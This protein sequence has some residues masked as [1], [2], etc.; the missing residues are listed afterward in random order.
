M[1]HIQK[2]VIPVISLV[3]ISTY[4]CAS[5]GEGTTEPGTVA[6]PTFS[7]ASGNYGLA[8]SVQITSAT[9]GAS[10][11]YTTNGTEPSCNESNCSSGSLYSSALNVDSSQT[12]KAI[13]CKAGMNQS[14]VANAEYLVVLIGYQSGDSAASVTG[15]L[16]LPS[17]DAKG[18]SVS[19][20]SSNTTAITNTG[21]ITRPQNGA[22]NA[23]ST[24]TATV[25]LSSGD[26]TILYDLTVLAWRLKT[27]KIYSPGPDEQLET[28]DDVWTTR[29]D[30]NHDASGRVTSYLSRNAGADKTFNTGDDSLSGFSYE[31]D[32]NGRR[33]YFITRSVGS[34]GTWFTDDDPFT[35]VRKYTYNANGKELKNL[36]YN[37]A[38]SDTNWKTSDDVLNNYILNGYDG[39]GFLTSAVSYGAVGS[40]ATW[41]TGDD[42]ITSY[43]VYTVNT[44][45]NPT[46][47]IQYSAA[48]SD[49]DW[50]ATADNVIQFK[51][52]YT[53][54]GNGNLTELKGLNA[55]DIVTYCSKS[56][57]DT[58]GN[59]TLNLTTTNAGVNGTWCDSDDKSPSNQKTVYEYY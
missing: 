52:S 51:R 5:E 18:A 34:D 43:G 30:Y 58:H 49:N 13:A 21:T 26:V 36:S 3:V 33:L 47:Y 44:E 7:A 57:Y 14:S 32:D 59:V 37:G 55:S 22:S 24:M 19:W 46:S 50:L 11:C 35:Q 23:S 20:S 38:G 17:T 39:N 9:D 28:A 16:T 4:Q 15:N 31:Y 56:S 53:Y 41:E 6:T 42:V 10:I 29:L 1:K 12:V 8:Q 40:D 48:G 54:D 25:S 27:A 2:F 45:G